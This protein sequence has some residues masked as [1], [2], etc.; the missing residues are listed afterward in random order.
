MPAIASS[1]PT[2]L[3][4]GYGSNLWLEQ[5]ARRCPDSTFVGIA[6]LDNYAWLINDR[7][8]A[9]VL[10]LPDSNSHVWGSVYTLTPSDEAR[11]DKNE[12]VPDIYAKEIMQAT[13]WAADV[14]GKA[15]P[16]ASPGRE[17]QM[18]VYIDHERTQPSTPKEE[19]IYRMNRGIED[20]LKAGIPA[21]YVQDVMRRYIPVDQTH[22]AVTEQLALKQANEFQ[23]E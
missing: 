13:L 11:L 8:Y 17:E 1:S 10:P 14:S 22:D 5:M 21:R 18:L 19:Y 2:S 6:R 9:N 20:A 15:D 4:F 3:Y 23:D 12:G 7:G 16:E